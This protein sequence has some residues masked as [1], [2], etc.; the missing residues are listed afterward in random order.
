MASKRLQLYKAYVFRGD[1][2]PVID[3]IHTML[4]D[5]HVN[6]TE[7]AEASGVGRGTIVQW[8][9]GKTM[10]PKYCTIAAVAA[11]LGYEPTFVKKRRNVVDLKRGVA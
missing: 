2:D 5:E 6:Y 7:A 10:R 8:I 3:K 11:A 1:K 9:E 4:E